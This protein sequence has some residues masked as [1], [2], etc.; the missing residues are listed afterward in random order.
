MKKRWLAGLVT[1]QYKKLPVT[2]KMWMQFNVRPRLLYVKRSA[3]TQH[4]WHG[5]AGHRPI[6]YQSVIV[7]KQL[8]VSIVP[9]CVVLS[10][11]LTG[12]ELTLSSSAQMNGPSYEELCKTSDEQLFNRVIDNKQHLLY[13][14]NLLPH[15]QLHRRITI[16]EK[17]STINNYHSAPYSNF[18][19]RM[20]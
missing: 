11:W 19:T 17:G 5:A 2:M 14:P 18:I 10:K 1:Q 13:R 9:A 4:V 12:C 20:L 8:Y 6:G 7:A 15:K 3:D 16:L